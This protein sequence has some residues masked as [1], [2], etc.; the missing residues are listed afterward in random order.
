MAAYFISM[1]CQS[2]V[3]VTWDMKEVAAL[4]GLFSG[5]WEIDSYLLQFCEEHVFTAVLGEMTRYRQKRCYARKNVLLTNEISWKK[6][7]FI[8]C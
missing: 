4:I 2:P 7:L 5:I 1:G 6:C 3:L 8:N